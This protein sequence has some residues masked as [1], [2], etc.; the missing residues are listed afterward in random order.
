MKDNELRYLTHIHKLLP[1]LAIPHEF[2]NNE[3]PEQRRRSWKV[4]VVKGANSLYSK[5]VFKKKDKYDTKYSSM[6]YFVAFID[7]WQVS[8]SHLHICI[9]QN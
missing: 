6:N 3:I 1:M 2:W 9:Q 8:W 4:S 7:K 5:T